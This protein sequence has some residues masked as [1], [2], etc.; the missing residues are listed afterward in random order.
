MTSKLVTG[1]AKVCA[2]AVKQSGD[3]TLKLR[4]VYIFQLEQP[5]AMLVLKALGGRLRPDS[6]LGDEIAQAK[7]LGDRL[8][9]ERANELERVA[10]QLR[11]SLMETVT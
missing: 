1:A 2:N 7:A 11:D 9:R 10:R 4:P 5:D 3:T 8:T 6:V